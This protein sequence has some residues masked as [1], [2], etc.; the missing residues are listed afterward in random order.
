MLV[1][2]KPD[3]A[4]NKRL[5]E[6]IMRPA[7]RPQARTEQD[8]SIGGHKTGQDRRQGGKR[9]TASRSI[10][11]VSGCQR[12][13]PMA[14]GAPSARE[15]AQELGAQAI[16]SSLPL[17][18]PLI[19]I[20]QLTLGSRLVCHL[21]RRLLWLIRLQVALRF[22]LEARCMWRPPGPQNSRLAQSGSVQFSPARLG[23][24][25]LG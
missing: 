23:S 5:A 21:S 11:R 17:T 19:L 14:C 3:S 9:P 4:A 12:R 13:W 10:D 16:G 6:F 24:A 18:W 15:R 1:T 2:L 8:R 7:R 22:R 25:W 20:D